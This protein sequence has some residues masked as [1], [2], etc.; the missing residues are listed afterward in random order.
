M[1]K[2]DQHKLDV[3]RKTYIKKLIVYRHDLAQLWLSVEQDS[4]HVQTLM[5]LS[6]RLAG[7]GKAYGFPELSHA[8]HELELQCDRVIKTSQERPMIVTLQYYFNAL[9]HELEQASGRQGTPYTEP[10]DTDASGHEQSVTTNIHLL[11][12][13]DDKDFS[14]RLHQELSEYGYNVHCLDDITQLNDAVVHFQPLAVLVDMDFYGDRYAGAHQVSLWRDRNDSPLPVI[15][16]SGFDH[17][18]VRLAAVRAGGNHFLKKPIDMPLLLSILSAELNIAPDDPYRVLLI[19]DDLDLLRLYET[20]LIDAGY[21]ALLATTAA[22]ALAMLEHDQPDLM[23]LDVYMPECDGIELGRLIRQHEQFSHI[24]LMFM[25]AAANTDVR[26]ACARLA[27]DEFI[28]KPIEPWRL[29]MVV[30]SRVAR[31]RQLQPY[32][33]ADHNHRSAHDLLTAL[34]S[35]AAFRHGIERALRGKTE[36]SLMAIL[37]IDVRYF[38]TINNLYGHFFG[39]QVLQRLAWELSQCLGQHDLLCRESG[40]EFLVLLSDHENLETVDRH[41]QRF[42][43]AIESLIFGADHGSI[44]LFADMGVVIGPTDSIDSDELI[45]FAD[46]ALFRAKKRQSP[47]VEYFTPQMQD[48]DATQLA[49]GVQTLKA[50][51]RQQF[52]AVYQPIFSI[53]SGDLVG[54][55]ALVRWQHPENGMI[56][57]ADFI[58]IMEEQGLI[59][60]LTLQMITQSLTQLANWRKRRP[61]VFVSLNLSALDIQKP[62]FL[63]HLQQQ[64][65]THQ[66]PSENIVLEITETLLLADWHQAAG[67]IQSLKNAGIKLALDDFGTGY[68]SLSYLSRIHAAKLKIDRSFIQG[69]TETGDDRLLRSMVQLGHTMNMRVIAEGVERPEELAF[70]RELGCDQYQGFLTAK[71]MFADE[72]DRYHWLLRN[73]YAAQ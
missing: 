50:L 30:K 49:L 65:A 43:R 71:P 8:A 39:D 48:E 66:I 1:G 53:A 62:L 25:S 54:F 47:T 16:I 37:K 42:V 21:T 68:S 31:S 52:I 36:A 19:D 12:V 7:S 40:D 2:S 61:D 15:F 57:P 13:D 45:R 18:S 26:L 32:T 70:L 73:A 56:G 51:E 58:P 20:V 3:L 17:F 5:A 11:L 14:Q 60:Q 63:N 9:M 6:H 35:L 24:P 22:E 10:L 28:H 67:L 55:E 64:M 69:W 23:L 27:N 29:L 33:H 38:H 41:I 72:I 59:S 4:T 34:P 46:M 44:S